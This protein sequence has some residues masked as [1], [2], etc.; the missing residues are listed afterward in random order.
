MI[1][2]CWMP[3][4][5]WEGAY[6]VSDLGRVRSLARTITYFSSQ[7]GKDVQRPVRAAV[8]R[9]K[10]N[11]SGHKQVTLTG[12]SDK[13]VH[14][15]VLE[16]FVGPRPAG[17][18][19]LHRNGDPSDNRRINLRWGT[20]GDNLRDMVRHGGHFSANKTSCPRGHDLVVPNLV[21][22]KLPRRQCLACDRAKRLAAY[23]GHNQDWIK[24]DADSRYAAIMSRG[25]RRAG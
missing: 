4:V 6:E 16:A 9:P 14:H 18:E 24:A 22:S 25:D 11:P 7:W 23:H 17:H 12:Q 13:W 19:G 8:L 15:L 5:G 10:T 21:K 20:R 2:E 3:V 1:G